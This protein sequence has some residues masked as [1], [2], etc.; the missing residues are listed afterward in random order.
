MSEAAYRIMEPEEADALFAEMG[1]R[2]EEHKAAEIAAGKR[3]LDEE[4]DRAVIDDWWEAAKACR[5]VEDACAFAH[6]LQD[7]YYHDY[8]TICHAVAAAGVAMAN[9][10]GLPAGITGFQ[11]GAIGW[12]LH[13]HWEQWD[14]SPRLLIDYG[15]VLFPQYDGRFTAISRDTHEWLIKKAK[16]RIAESDGLVSSEVWDRWQLIADGQL[17]AFLSVQR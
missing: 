8:G 17:P 4:A 1:K 16:E 11:G 3:P 6:Q 9:A 13:R 12:M 5:S 14:D 2:V 10:V 15:K 7:D